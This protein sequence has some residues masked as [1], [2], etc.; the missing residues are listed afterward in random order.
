[1]R[2]PHT[3]EGGL[4]RQETGIKRKLS[5]REGKGTNMDGK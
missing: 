2:K 4:E 3:Y 1:M 5:C